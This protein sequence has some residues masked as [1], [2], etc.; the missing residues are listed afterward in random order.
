MSNCFKNSSRFASLLEDTNDK[1][2]NHITA[3]N[4][5]QFREREP[6]EREPR[7][8]EPREREDTGNTFKQESRNNNFRRPTTNRNHYNNNNKSRTTS[9]PVIVKPEFN[10]ETN[11]FPELNNN[12][13]NNNNNKDK[14]ESTI[15]DCDFE[16]KNTLLKKIDVPVNTEIK[17]TFVKK[18][19]VEI[20]GNNGNGNIEYTYGSKNQYL[21]YEEELRDLYDSNINFFMSREIDK[22]KQ[23]WD[24]YK[25]DYNEIYGEGAYEDLYYSSPVYGSEYDSNS[26]TMM[27][28]EDDTD[29][30]E[31]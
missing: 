8:R 12:N 16:F 4:T 28:E 30:N 6:R 3:H 5:N 25:N 22:M 13:N 20:K 1:V 10:M 26:D 17:Q 14:N 7:E 2:N 23:R 29:E 24:K 21:D 18:G 31:Y 15:H 27:E 9:L 11:L 19:W